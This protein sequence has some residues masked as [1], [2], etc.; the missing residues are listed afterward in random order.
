MPKP[1]MTVNVV[2]KHCDALILDEAPR[3][4]I[5]PHSGHHRALAG[6]TSTLQ[7]QEVPST[8]LQYHRVVPILRALL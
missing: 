7:L 5:H 2:P 8:D 1:S 6:G 3:C 4:Q